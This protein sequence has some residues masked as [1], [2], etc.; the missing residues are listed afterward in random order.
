MDVNKT[1][2]TK[3]LLELIAKYEASTNSE[4]VKKA[5]RDICEIILSLEY[6][7]ASIIIFGNNGAYIP[8][9]DESEG[10]K[11]FPSAILPTH[12]KQTVFYTSEN[13]YYD[14]NGK[15]TSCNIED[16]IKNF[17]PLVKKNPGSN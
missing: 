17:P 2:T 16:A 12:K 11:L 7:R 14:S 3:M 4:E 8:I 13:K 10:Y 15:L 1:Q 9:P 5:E 6:P